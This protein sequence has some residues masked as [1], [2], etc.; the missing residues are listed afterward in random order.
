MTFFCAC[1]RWCDSCNKKKSLFLSPN[2]VP[3]VVRSETD[4]FGSCIT[5]SSLYNNILECRKVRHLE[6]CIVLEGRYRVSLA[7][8]S[9]SLLCSLFISNATEL[10]KRTRL[11]SSF[12]INS[13]LNWNRRNT[14]SQPQKSGVQYLFTKH[15]LF[16]RGTLFVIA[17]QNWRWTKINSHFVQSN[18]SRKQSFDFCITSVPY[19]FFFWN[20]TP[21]VF[22]WT[23]LFQIW[24]PFLTM[25]SDLLLWKGNSGFLG[26]LWGVAV[27]PM[28][29]RMSRLASTSIEVSATCLKQQGS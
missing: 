14:H 7:R 1:P 5:V 25:S 27:T 10:E 23:C 17:R 11:T 9:A 28:P 18:N 4:I 12:L 29:K 6:N 24:F 13:V 2:G 20:K 3:I 15:W 26:I 19:I 16:E 8:D 21:S 22:L